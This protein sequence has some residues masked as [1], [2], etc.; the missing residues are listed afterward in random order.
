[1]HDQL[2]AIETLIAEGRSEDAATALLDLVKDTGPNFDDYRDELVSLNAEFKAIG[3]AKR[4]SEITFQEYQS[5]LA[6]LSRHV[7]ELVGLIRDRSA[8]RK[9]IEPA[10]M[11]AVMRD[12][13]GADRAS[14]EKI[15]GRD[16]LQ[17]LSWFERGLVCSTSVCRVV[18]P[19]GTGTGFV[20]PGGYVM[21]NNHV[22][23]SME[24]ALDTVFEFNFEH[25]INGHLKD[26]VRYSADPEP[27]GFATSPIDE[28]DCSILRVAREDSG[29]V[30]ERWG[31]LDLGGSEP[32]LHDPVSIIQHP[33]GGQKKICVTS[34]EIVSLSGFR[35]FYMTDTLPGSSGAPVFSDKW[36][37]V[38]LHRAGG[39][40]IVT[41][42]GREQFANEGIAVD[43]IRQHEAFARFFP[44]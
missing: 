35:V 4:M 7:V 34:N 11:P 32:L 25:D 1:M 5:T 27:D 20:I 29:D 8:S 28:L 3:R 19:A 40:R 21:T 44:S 42:D 16:N 10:P 36:K 31:A 13:S 17:D 41:Q 2:L 23:P 43:A 22:V 30:S 12:L 14:P 9:P 26:I 18:S 15:Y 38:A 39:A 37:V 33:E 6:R 24:A